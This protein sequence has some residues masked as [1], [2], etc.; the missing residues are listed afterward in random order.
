MGGLTNNHYLFN[1]LDHNN[2][3][4]TSSIIIQLV[5]NHIILLSQIEQ[6]VATLTVYIYVVSR[7]RKNLGRLLSVLFCSVHVGPARQ[8]AHSSAGGGKSINT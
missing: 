3:N 6:T 8:A 7:H 2:N 1:S 5:G 4:Y